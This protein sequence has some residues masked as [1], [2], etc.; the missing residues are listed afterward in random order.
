MQINNLMAEHYSANKEG[1]VKP[2]S[3][4]VQSESVS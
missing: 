4:A 3:F 2:L 1:R